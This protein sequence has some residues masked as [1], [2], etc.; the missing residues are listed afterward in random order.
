MCIVTIEAL[1]L[2]AY[3]RILETSGSRDVNIRFVAVGARIYIQ[4]DH[5]DHRMVSVLHLLR[6]TRKTTFSCR[7]LMVPISYVP[8]E[9]GRGYLFLWIDDDVP[10]LEEGPLNAKPVLSTSASKMFDVI[11]TL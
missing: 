7:P 1:S 4:N 6:A 9:V 5:N 10:K 3:K 11:V 8:L 2:C